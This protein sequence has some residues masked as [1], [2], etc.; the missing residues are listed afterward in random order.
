MMQCLPD[1]GKGGANLAIVVGGIGSGYHKR[2]VQQEM[3][4]G[5][6]DGRVMTTSKQLMGR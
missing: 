4:P 5:L 2:T 6:G 1:G 3:S